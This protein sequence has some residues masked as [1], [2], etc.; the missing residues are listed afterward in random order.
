MKTAFVL[1]KASAEGGQSGIKTIVEEVKELSGVVEIHRILGPFDV[2]VKAET[3]DMDELTKL[4]DEIR[5]IYGTKDTTT[6]P[7]H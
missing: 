1:I 4:I 7:V 2:I 3:E 6:L 5:N